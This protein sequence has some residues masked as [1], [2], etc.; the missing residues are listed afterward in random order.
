MENQRPKLT[1]PAEFALIKQMYFQDNRPFNDN[2]DPIERNDR[3]ESKLKN[4]QKSSR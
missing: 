1:D 3:Q 2:L 4:K